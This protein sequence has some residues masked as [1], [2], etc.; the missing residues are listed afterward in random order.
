MTDTWTVRGRNYYDDA[1]RW[2]WE[3]DPAVS[4]AE[5]ICELLDALSIAEARINRLERQVGFFEAQHAR[6]GHAGA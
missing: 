5:R 4:N 1:G 6:D 3:P 2:T